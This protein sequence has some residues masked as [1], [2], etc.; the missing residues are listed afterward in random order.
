MQRYYRCCFL[1]REGVICRVE[2]FMAAGDNRAVAKAERLFDG[3]AHYV[4]FEVW[5]GS[6]LLTV[7]RRS[8]IRD[9]LTGSA[10]L[11]E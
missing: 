9:R 10:R 1:N 2:G 3:F 4:G 5:Q 8:I 7:K 11:L 6:R